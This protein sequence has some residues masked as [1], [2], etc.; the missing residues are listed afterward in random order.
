MQ[1]KTGIIF[2]EEKIVLKSFEDFK[3]LAIEI[4][5]YKE[6]EMIPLTDEEIK[7]Y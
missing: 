2:I 6:Q 1:Q 4:I 7:F 5:N 3:E